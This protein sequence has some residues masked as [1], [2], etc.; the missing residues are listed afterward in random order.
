MGQILGK[1][2][3]DKYELE[4][5]IADGGFSAVYMA[6]RKNSG[7]R[8]AVKVIP[9]QKDMVRFNRGEIEAHESLEHAAIVKLLGMHVDQREIRL[10]QEFVENGTLLDFARRRTDMGKRTAGYFLA[11][12]V[13]GLMYMH[14]Q[15][16]VHRDIKLENLLIS[17]RGV[18]KIVDFGFA[19]RYRPGCH[20]TDPR[21]GAIFTD[22]LGSERYMSPEV[23]RGERYYGPPNDVWACGVVLYCLVTSD[24]PWQAPV[25]EE[26]RF[27]AWQ[28]HGSIGGCWNDRC[29]RE[30]DGLL[31]RIFPVDPLQRVDIRTIYRHSYI[32][33]SLSN[34]YFTTMRRRVSA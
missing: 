33:E 8:A 4:Y 3:K 15:G 29:D 23:Y 22:R 28:Q 20:G 32:Q 30:M 12:L 11:Q 34:R 18:L 1:H 7:V 25:P 9:R 13:S 31:R 27:A 16:F 24:F 14:G 10:Y 5:K 19:A 6:R 17:S 21:L 2:R 26:A